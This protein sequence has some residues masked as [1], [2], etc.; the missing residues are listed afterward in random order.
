MDG[1]L[2]CRAL[3][4]S[5]SSAPPIL[6]AA[7]VPGDA[8]GFIGTTVAAA[9]NGQA[10]GTAGT[11]EGLPT[12]P[13]P[14]IVGPTADHLQAV[15]DGCFSQVTAEA[16]LTVYAEVPTPS[17]TPVPLQVING[18]TNSRAV[19]IQPPS[20]GG[21]TVRIRATF[22]TTDGSTAW[23]ELL[24]RVLVPFDPPALTMTRPGMLAAPRPSRIAPANKL[25]TGASASDQC[26]G[27]YAPIIESVDPLIPRP[28]GAAATQL[29]SRPGGRSSA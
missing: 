7:A 12:D 16:Q 29:D 25:A 23:S 9:W 14:I 19:D 1:S 2:P 8:I 5:Q 13:A 20:V 17:P 24:F 21:W 3:D 18:G 4:P 22:V 15:S 11:W 6:V 26:G 27:T 10:T 28:G